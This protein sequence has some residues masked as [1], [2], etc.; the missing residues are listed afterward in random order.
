[1]LAFILLSLL[2]AEVSS[3]PAQMR[4]FSYSGEYGGKNGDP[5]DQSSNLLDGPI[6]ALRIRA[7]D[8]YIV[9]IQVRYGDSWSST[10]GIL[11]G[12]PSGMQLF[13]GEGFVQVL[14]RF[15]SYVEYLAFHTNVG[16]VFAFGPSSGSGTTFD[17]EPLFPNTILR[18]ISG[19]SGPLVN[20][21]GFHWDKEQE[22][23]GCNQSSL[24]T[25]QK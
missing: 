5:F 15:G 17:A 6:T 11:L 12:S 4:F 22:I 16:R 20:A 24:S 8:R 21:V 13:L 9:S 3:N 18:F 1:M 14:G 2:Y 23:G 25:H 7:N 19:R 10:E